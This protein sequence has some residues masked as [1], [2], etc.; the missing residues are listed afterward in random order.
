ME[1]N[2]KTSEQMASEHT[3]ENLLKFILSTTF[4]RHAKLSEEEF[5][6]ATG[7]DKLKKPENEAILV[8]MYNVFVET[9][10]AFVNA[11]TYL[12]KTIGLLEKCCLD[13]RTAEEVKKEMKH[14][15]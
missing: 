11:K 7:L 6:K 2:K 8:G 5:L 14:G 1:K 15:K 9:A 13:G 10:A 4:A 12:E 3:G